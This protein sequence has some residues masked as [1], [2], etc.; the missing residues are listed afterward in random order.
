MLTASRPLPFTLL[1]PQVIVVAA[2]DGPQAEASLRFAAKVLDKDNTVFHIVQVLPHHRGTV[3]MRKT[4][5]PGNGH[6]GCLC[7]AGSDES[8]GG[9]VALQTSRG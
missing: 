9:V 8:L 5:I 3:S 6:I 4:N 7:L 1:Y 2:D